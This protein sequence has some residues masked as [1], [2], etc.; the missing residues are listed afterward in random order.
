MTREINPTGG[1]SQ[2][3]PAGGCGYYVNHI[4]FIQEHGCVNAEKK[5]SRI[6]ELLAGNLR[7][8][9]RLNINYLSK[10]GYVRRSC[11]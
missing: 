2:F 5:R 3:P 11:K 4:N 7:Q 10:I 6:M 9:T 1:Q 8:H